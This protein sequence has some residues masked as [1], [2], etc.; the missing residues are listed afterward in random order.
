MK[1]KKIVLLSAVVG[2][3]GLAGVGYS[4]QKKVEERK[5]QDRI[6]QIRA[7]FSVMG[8]IQVL[9][10]KAYESQGDQVTG[11]VVFEDGRVLNFVFDAGQ[12]SYEEESHD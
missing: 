9:Y 10:I 2:I 11:G 12:I 5:A 6:R 7:Y 3:V 1:S 8:P 4:I